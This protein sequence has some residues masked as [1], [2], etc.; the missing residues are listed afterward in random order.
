RTAHL[1]GRLQQ[2]LIGTWLEGLENP[3]MVSPD[4]LIELGCGLHRNSLGGRSGP[5]TSS[6]N[7]RR[8]G[9]LQ[10]LQRLKVHTPSYSFAYGSGVTCSFTHRQCGS[11]NQRSG[12]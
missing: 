11:S 7:V 4:S 5:D 10:I 6:G 8:T 12:R 1:V 2:D 9:V 3:D